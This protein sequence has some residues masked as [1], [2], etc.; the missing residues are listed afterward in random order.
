M[1]IVQEVR[2][3]VSATDVAPAASAETSAC[4]EATPVPP[5]SVILA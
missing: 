4:A 3:G 5:G 1:P 2:Q